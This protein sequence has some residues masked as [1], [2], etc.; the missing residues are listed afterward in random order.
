MAVTTAEFRDNIIDSGYVLDPEGIHHEFVSGKHGR[1]L[2]FDN[3]P[4]GSDLFGQ[5]VEVTARELKGE[6]TNVDMGRFALVSVANGTNRLVGPVAETMG[7]GVTA[8]LTQKDPDH[9]KQVL[10]PGGEIDKLQG[11][12]ASIAVLLEDVGTTG[13][14]T[15][16]GV[17][18][19]RQTGT[20][21]VEVVMAW[22]RQLRL[23]RL[24]A[25]GAAYWAIIDEELPTY[26]P[27]ECRDIGYCALGWQYIPR[28]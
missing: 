26:D 11:L 14:T 21:N 3:I 1:K 9:P 15:A 24:D 16:T 17:L 22:K 18:S 27:D 6:Y 10:L 8:I 25:I 13:S 28:A 20:K 5:W 23:E 4:D 7:R 19:V 2:D 12:D